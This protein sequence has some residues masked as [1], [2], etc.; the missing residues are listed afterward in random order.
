MQIL[1][2]QS[3]EGR[4][5]YSHKPVI[6]ISAD[7]GE[8]YKNPTKD[9]KGFN[10]KILEYFPGISKHYCSLGYEGGFMERLV[11]GTYIGHVAEHMIIELQKMLGYDVCY[12]KTRVVTEPSLYYIVYEYKNEKCGIEC[13]RI[14]FEVINSILNNEVVDFLSKFKNLQAISVGND[15]GPS[16]KAIYTEAQK[17]GIPVTRIGN[18]SMIQLGYGKHSRMLQASLTD[19]P[20][21]IAVDTVSNKDLTK[22]ILRDFMIPVPEGEVSYS[23]EGAIYIAQEIGFPVVVKPLDGNQGRGVTINIKD[24]KEVR[25]AFLEAKKISNSILIEKYVSGKDYR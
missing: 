12:G 10:E 4:N 23:E 7:I 2:I 9:I 14:V 18:G 13:A 17:R 8:Q 6:K 21:C 24:E 16:T 15:L 20:S 19:L 22:R 5:I 1:N 11:E 25:A 3:F